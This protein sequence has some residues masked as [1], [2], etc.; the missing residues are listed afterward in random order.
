MKNILFS[1]LKFIL[2]Q[3]IMFTTIFSVLVMFNV[4]PMMKINSGQLDVQLFMRTLFF[5]CFFHSFFNSLIIS[6]FLYGILILNFEKKY[7]IFIFLIPLAVSGILC[8][9][10]VY[11][12][13]PG[14][15]KINFQVYNDARVFFTEKSFLTIKDS[16]PLIITKDDFRK[17]KK[18]NVSDNKNDLQ[19]IENNYLFN[20]KKDDYE[21]QKTNDKT[22]TESIINIFYKYDILKEKKLYFEKI[23]ENTF[24]NC[25]FVDG[26]TIRTYKT[27]NISY[28]EDKIL[29][30]FDKYNFE[31]AKGQLNEYNI[32]D[33]I[34]SRILFENITKITYN[35]V[36]Y[37]KWYEN[38]IL[39]MSVLYL[40]LSFCMIVM[41]KNFPLISVIIKFLL[42][43]GFYMSFFYVLTIFNNNIS[44]FV[45]GIVL[46]Y[47]SILFPMVLIFLGLILNLFN[48]LFFKNN[49]WEKD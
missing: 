39:F 43:M 22:N 17:I 12:L 28:L 16:L 4:F 42:L 33:S 29:V 32:Y 6:I 7:R 3:I 40:I 9:L 23:E 2:I 10:V 20:S 34:I 47:K 24:K 21:L 48:F 13:N 49:V 36:S 41:K 5:P 25:I 46:K 19:I 27:I 31:F 45:T 38:L 26:D 44:L 8:F 1:F 30:S 37:K 35:F 18:T 15:E 14:P 11:F